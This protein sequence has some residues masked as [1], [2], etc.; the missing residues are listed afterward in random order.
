MNSFVLVADREWVHGGGKQGS[1]EKCSERETER[2]SLLWYVRKT[3]IL[4]N[5]IRSS[6]LQFFKVS[7][8]PMGGLVD[9]KGKAR[10]FESEWRGREHCYLS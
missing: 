10:S 2:H 6:D 5:G 4:L 9:C 1:Y 7:F 3:Y 8:S